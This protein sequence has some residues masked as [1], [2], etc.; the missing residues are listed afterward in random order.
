LGR[1][2]CLAIAALAVA[3]YTASL[4][5][6]FD[7]LQTVCLAEPCGLSPTLEEA[8]AWAAAGL[9]VRFAAAYM[10][11][12]TTLNALIYAA[13][14]AIIF[15]QRP[16]DRAAWF[17]ALMLVTFGTF[18]VQAEIA[19]TLGVAFHPLG[20]PFI[21]ALAVTG[22]LL[23]VVFFFIFPDGRFAPRWLR[24]PL[25]VFAGWSVLI[26][27]FPTTWLNYQLWPLWPNLIYWGLLFGACC[28]AQIYRYRH[29]SNAI[30]RQ[31]TKWA[32]FG[33]SLMAGGA[34]VAYALTSVA[35]TFGPGWASLALLRDTSYFPFMPLM[36]LSIGLAIL[37][38]RLWDIDI[39][40]RRTLVYSILT[41]LLALVYFTSIVA[42]QTLLRGLTGGESPLVVVLSTLLIAALFAPVRA[43][44]QVMIDR[45]FYRRKYDAARTLALF[46]SQV[47]DETDL[48]RLTQRLQL[49]V[50]DTMQPA[51]LSLWLKERNSL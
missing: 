15:W 1:V 47:R 29:H 22:N 5:I 3:L 26:A 39:L 36:P 48:S 25:A 42:L 30:Q 23:I 4:P 38:S 35:P 11:T 46:G 40:I 31:Q 12:L 7:Q 9:S 10:L 28:Y 24:L 19:S 37:R 45:R 50:E 33:F 27:V 43:W 13:V 32:I 41:G 17:T 34:F 8:R 49:A 14:A 6:Q 20:R 51:H 21:L 18:G 16:A 2:L 44:V